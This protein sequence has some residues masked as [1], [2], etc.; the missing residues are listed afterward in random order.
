MR[1]GPR[2]LVVGNPDVIHV[3]AHLMRAAAGLGVHAYICDS[4]RAFA[5]AP[6]R[7]KVA[8]W[9]RGHRPARLRAFSADVVALAKRIRPDYVLATGL[10]PLDAAA[11]ASLGSLG[12]TRLNFL[13]DD[14]WNRAHRAPWFMES[15]GQYDEVYS[16]RRANLGD[17][18]RLAGPRASYLPFAY[19]PDLHFPDPPDSRE[20]RARFDADVMFAG[21]ADRDRARDLRAFRRAGFAVALYG[22]YWERHRA[23]RSLGRGHLDPAGLRRATGGA[24]VCLCL[25][26][27]ANRDGHS[28]RS[29]EIPAMGGCMVVEDTREHRDLF[30]PDGQ[31]VVYFSR[32]EEAVDKTRR[33]LADPDARQDLAHAAHELVTRGAHTYADRLA[34]MLRL[35]PHEAPEDRDRRPRTLSRV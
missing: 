15:L 20:E 21:G 8:W 23:L 10:A 7:R 33:L 13:T 4:R 6:W 27:R 17:L 28:M 9:A 14:P 24:R 1:T 2:L 32:I 30:G 22:G 18:E 25:V 5:A 29:F 11:L 35:A 34:V 16:P 12:I 19:A 31:A 26:R 3:G